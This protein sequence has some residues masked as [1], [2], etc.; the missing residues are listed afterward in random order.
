M[1]R[2]DGTGPQGMGPMT[3]R[4]AGYCAGYVNPGYANSYGRRFAGA[5]R[6]MPG[7]AGRGRGH[8]NQYYATG[9]PGWTG[10]RAGMPV[11]G[12]MAPYPNAS[13]EPEI[14]PGQEVEMLKEEQNIL[15]QQLVDIEKRMS[16]IK[17]EKKKEK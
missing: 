6:G 15:K 11:E 4:A 9:L 8:R 7:G 10:Y 12:G 2:G 16:E 5:A 17:R 1:P 14:E 3:G 13:Y